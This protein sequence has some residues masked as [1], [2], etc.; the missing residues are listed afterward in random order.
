MHAELAKHLVKELELGSGSTSEDK[1]LRRIW[2]YMQVMVKSMAQC[3]AAEKVPIS[4]AERFGTAYKGNICELVNAMASAV[5]AR[6]KEDLPLCKAINSN[7]A[8]FIQGMFSLMDRSI[9]FKLVQLY[10]RVLHRDFEKDGNENLAN[11]KL[12]FLRI[13]CEHEHYVPLNLIMLDDVD[14]VV[15][16]SWVQS[17]FEKR[18]VLVGMVLQELKRALHSGAPTLRRQCIAIVCGLLRKHDADDRYSTPEQ[19][20]CIAMLYFPLVNLVLDNCRSLSGFPYKTR[21][22]IPHYSIGETRDLLFCFLWVLHNIDYAYVLHWWQFEYASV[23]IMLDVLALCVQTFKYT[24]KKHL[25]TELSSP[26][27]STQGNLSALEKLY[28]PGGITGARRASSSVGLM[29][30]SKTGD[31]FGRKRSNSDAT[32]IAGAGGGGGGGRAGSG[33][34][35]P[36]LSPIGSNDGSPARVQSEMSGSS[37]D[38][39]STSSPSMLGNDGSASPSAAGGTRFSRFQSKT[40]T[41]GVAPANVGE[42]IS[43]MSNL[44]T[45]LNM[46]VL[47][48]VDR[49]MSDQPS[50]IRNKN[51]VAHRA[52]SVLFEIHTVG[53][54]VRL[55]PS[56]SAVID[57]FITHYSDILYQ[58]NEEFCTRLC[59]L[60]LHACNS[61][62]Q[63][64][65]N[66]ACTLMYRLLRNNP[67]RVSQELMVAVS[68]LDLKDHDDDCLRTSLVAIADFGKHDR[69]SPSDEFPAEVERLMER[70]R[71]V[72]LDTAEMEHYGNDHEML[73][74]LQARVADSYS[75]TPVLRL[76][77]LE[78]LA[79]LHVK[80]ANWSEAGMCV[81]YCGALI[82]EH[83][84]A[85]DAENAVIPLGSKAFR[86]ISPTLGAVMLDSFENL[87]D[88]RPLSS[89]GAGSPEPLG[90]DGVTLTSPLF[91]ER[92]LLATLPKAVGF[93]KKAQRYEL[94]SR[95][96]ALFLPIYERDR[97]YEELAL[98]CKDMQEC[99]NKIVK[100]REQEQSGHQ[101]MLGIYYR[102]SFHG[103]LFGDLDGH[104]YIYKEADGE[105]IAGFLARLKDLHVAR[106]GASRVNMIQE[107]KVDEADLDD[108]LAHIQVI[109]VEPYLTET[110]TLEKVGAFECNQNLRCFILETPFTKGGKARGSA[111]T[112][113]M[114]QLI[115]HVEDGHS[116]PSVK[117]RL[118]VARNET[119]ILEP[120]DV[121]IRAMSKKV[122]ELRRVVYAK[123][124]AGRDGPHPD[125]IS[126]QLQLQ[127][128]VSIQVN[129]GPMEYVNVFLSEDSSD[130]LDPLK[131]EELQ[132]CFAAMLK[133]VRH[134][135][136]RNEKSIGEDQK[137]YQNDLEDNAQ[138]MEEKLEPMLAGLASLDDSTA[139]GAGAGGGGAGGSRS[140]GSIEN[141]LGNSSLLSE[142]RTT[143]GAPELHFLG[144]A[145]QPDM[146]YVP[147][148]G[149]VA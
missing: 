113:C 28:T 90:G 135:L 60:L 80:N 114:E 125:I 132:E 79:Q 115:M 39:L 92:G 94:V 12:D 20:S 142:S 9:G 77:W 110:E 34:Q 119:I 22:T 111:A 32:N 99:F 10:L 100:C 105:R 56:W 7:T 88:G 74:D 51:S 78:R 143:T 4:Q 141:L 131:V 43:S 63:E 89:N 102:V 42:L 30:P 66:H 107:S 58:T 108:K 71:R 146:L 49:L 8:F 53:L 123:G 149:S 95:I 130:G 69:N 134:G 83:L 93:F 122:S 103:S 67:A 38:A 70:L 52:I 11:F 101:R 85:V 50:L 76:V 144:R 96:Y 45:D 59:T 84:R 54:S 138:Q 41:A 91:S 3:C 127:G 16:P 136:L 116:F 75:K 72:R 82:A 104:E 27:K 61:E 33:R 5:T 140:Q 14:H 148:R 118:R 86:N 47:G 117:K 23:E 18:H 64:V 137:A 147:T 19:M 124:S 121:A 133:L 46:V 31:R 62:L 128:I 57:S 65:R 112:Q 6:I 48:L 109:S 44:A 13:V 24:G 129:E 15:K 87:A 68:K 35:S 81:C 2:F 145:S 106:F 98:A 36:P 73:A 40:D 29:S 126:L 1:I 97:M 17:T 37:S 25:N 26:S 21:Q 120:I 55:A 139:G